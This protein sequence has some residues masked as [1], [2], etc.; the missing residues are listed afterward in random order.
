MYEYLLRSKPHDADRQS[1][2]GKQVQ[3]LGY[4]PYNSRNR[5]GHALLQRRA[6]DK[7]LLAEQDNPNRNNDHAYDLYKSVK[8]SDHLRNLFIIHSLCFQSKLGYVGI[9]PHLLDPGPALA[10]YYK[11]AGKQRIPGFFGYL[12]RF[13]RDQRLIDEELAILHHRIRRDLITCRKNNNIIQHNILGRNH[14]LLSVTQDSALRRIQDTQVVEYLL[15]TQLLKDTDQRVGN[16]DR[17]E[18]Q[19]PKRTHK[20]QQYGDH[21]KDKI[22][23]RKN[24]AVY[25]L[26]F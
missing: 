26:L 19:I 2:A 1:N 11:A 16:N 9:L 7:I 18:S 23:I 15:R 5:S 22:E 20:Y 21:K 3:A 24:I 6:I 8:G 4:H 12:I 17:K 13:S 10:G 14:F 25:D